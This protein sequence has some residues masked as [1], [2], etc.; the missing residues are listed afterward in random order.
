MIS[1]IL[2]TIETEEEYHAIEQIYSLYYKRM[3][4]VAMN[5]LHNQ[6][7]AEDAVMTTIK[8]MCDYPQKFLEYRSSKTI[9][10]IHTKIK[11]TAIDI[12]RR[13]Q[14]RFDQCISLNEETEN[15]LCDLSV[16]EAL[17]IEV[18]LENREI[19]SKALSEMK[20]DYR[21]PIVLKYFHQM[22]TKEI[23]EFLN[24]SESVVDVRIH[25]GKLMLK[26]ICISM[27]YRK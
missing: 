19:M 2:T 1:A 26:E 21:I 9:D 7:D 8:Y 4:A 23:A 11:W 22:K 27:G 13:N 6:A 16:N 12:Y 20:P 15:F 3:I 17:E 5:V 10:L 25:R 14:N 18:N 24:V